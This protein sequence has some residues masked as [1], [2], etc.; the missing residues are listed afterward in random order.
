MR[1]MMN[2]SYG[3]LALD[4]DEDRQSGTGRHSDAEPESASQADRP[5]LPDA[6]HA[7][8]EHG[9]FAEGD[10]GSYPGGPA[11]LAPVAFDE[12]DEVAVV[13]E[14]TP[15]QRKRHARLV[16]LVTVTLGSLVGLLTVGVIRAHTAKPNFTPARPAIA[17]SRRPASLPVSEARRVSDLEPRAVDAPVP[18]PPP[19]PPV[20]HENAAPVATSSEGAR[21]I[22]PRRHAPI[23]VAPPAALHSAPIAPGPVRDEEASS[24]S[25]SSIP[26]AS[27]SPVV[28]AR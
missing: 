26:T 27:F 16:R 5:T 13:R 3:N 14:R 20:A 1:P 24:A 18:A 2:W 8:D 21:R 10:A 25:R 17:A 28:T 22:A 9:F 6:L 11:T 23:A 19:S 15:A 4:G 7:M 12:P